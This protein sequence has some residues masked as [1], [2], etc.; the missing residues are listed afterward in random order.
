MAA[1]MKVAGAAEIVAVIE[2]VTAAVEETA[3]G[4]RRRIVNNIEVER[5]YGGTSAPYVR[6]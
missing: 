2:V 3:T 4:D 1:A 6:S 5:T